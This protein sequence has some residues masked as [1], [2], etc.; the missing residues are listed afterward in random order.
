MSASAAKKSSLAVLATG[1]ALAAILTG[2][3]SGPFK[4]AQT[5]SASAPT[6]ASSTSAP[7]VTVVSSASAPAPTVASSTSAPSV[8][9]SVPAPTS[10]TAPR[11]HSGGSS[12]LIGNWTTTNYVQKSPTGAS[13]SGGAGI[14]LTIS[15]NQMSANFD[16]MQPVKLSQAAITE[17][18]KFS[19]TETAAIAISGTGGSGQISVVASKGSDV[20]F[21]A[22]LPSGGY[23]SPISAHSFPSAGVLGS[24]TCSGSAMALTVTP[25]RAS[26]GQTTWYLSRS[27]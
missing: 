9:T 20:T 17:Q 14:A 26:D 24:W 21:E 23:S 6:V 2:C 15:S 18:G 4:S 8:T 5:S 19:G 25:P 16:N 7:S 11:A 12:C 13:T 1:A 27:V 10:T 3:G 22:I